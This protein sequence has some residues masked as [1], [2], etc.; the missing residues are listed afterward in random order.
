VPSIKQSG[1]SVVKSMMKNLCF[2]PDSNQWSSSLFRQHAF[3]LKLLKQL[4]SN[5][6]EV[7]SK[8]NEIRESITRPDKM[9]VHLAINLERLKQKVE[10]ESAWLQEFLPQTV[11]PAFMNSNIKKC[12]E[13]LQPISGDGFK[14]LI[15]GLGAIESSFLM[16][17]AVC[18]IESRT[19][20]DY[21]PLLVLNNYLTQCEGPMWRQIRGNGL[22]YSYDIYVSYDT[23]LIYFVLSKSTHLIKAYKEALNIIDSHLNGITKWDTELLESARSSLMFELIEQ[24]KTVSDVVSCSIQSYCRN[25]GMDFTKELKELLEKVSKVTTTEMER[26]GMQYLKPLFSPEVSRCTVT[27]NPSKVKD[28]TEEFKKLSRELTVVPSLDENFMSKY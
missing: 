13:Y 3:L 5:P 9:V 8:L 22:A 4:E 24:I 1:S 10:P 6:D 19:H 28:I 11:S 7:V 18:L 26:V 25:S 12:S 21:A 23:G 27:C 15:A 14:G 17:S 20:P 16:Q 2:R